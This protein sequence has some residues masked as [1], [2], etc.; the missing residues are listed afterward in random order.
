MTRSATASLL[1]FIILITA[2]YLFAAA[3]TGADAV[4]GGFLLNPQD[5]NTYLSKMH[6]GQQ[7][8]WLFRLPFTRD[9][10]EG[11][12]L[13]GFYLFLG[14][15]SRWSNLPII[16]VFH[17]ARI[18]AA[19]LM[20]AA[21]WRFYSRYAPPRRIGWCHGISLLGLG[22]GWAVFPAGIVLSDFWVAEAYPFLSSYVNPHFPLSLAVMLYLL[23]PVKPHGGIHARRRACML[24]LQAA[25]GAMLSL[26]SPFGAVLTV[27]IL[28]ASLAIGLFRSGGV[29]QPGAALMRLRKVGSED[30][31]LFLRTAAIGIG[32]LPLSAHYLI[33]VRLHPQLAVWNT[34]NLTLTPAVWDIFLALS[35]VILLAAVGAADQRI[36]TE[37]TRLLTI[38]VIIA[39]VFMYSPI[40]LQRR[41]MMGLY[42]P[43]TALAAWGLDWIAGR[44]ESTAGRAAVLAFGLALP[45]TALILTMGFIGA[46]SAEPTLYY[47]QGESKALVWIEAN[48]PRDALILAAPETALLI[49]AH[50]GRRVVYGHPYETVYAAQEKEAV[51]SFFR[52]RMSAPAEFLANNSVDFVFYGQHERDLGELP[53]NLPL[54]IVFSEDGTQLLQVLQ[55]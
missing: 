7:G 13:F 43:L 19:I 32:A 4:F 47:S 2:P 38:W 31:E 14:H 37:R 28:G 41:F 1:L 20:A 55:R 30:N 39:F 27:G 50:T 45:S 10:G 42:V 36:R 15:A 24:L 29:R 6:Q 52:G 25:G 9:P 8:D 35:P 53:G 51:E 23:V 16:Y 5:G 12:F 11:V 48:T 54:K 40:G 33:I 49:P 44:G 26:L 46:A 34:Q 3:Q 18:A 22:M 21:L 17:I